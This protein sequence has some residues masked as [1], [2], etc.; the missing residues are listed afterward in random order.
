ML[1]RFKPLLS[2]GYTSGADSAVSEE[3]RSLRKHREEGVSFSVHVIGRIFS[4]LQL[5]FNLMSGKGL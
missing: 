2:S 1:L 4:L 3:L 5:V